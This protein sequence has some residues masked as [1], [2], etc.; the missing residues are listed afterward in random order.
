VLSTRASAVAVAGPALRDESLAF[1]RD[2]HRAAARVWVEAA[3]RA[4]ADPH[5]LDRMPVRWLGR[6]AVLVRGLLAERLLADETAVRR[7]GSLPRAL[8]VGALGRGGTPGVTEGPD[9]ASLACRSS[10]LAR[11]LRAAPA[12]QVALALDLELDEMESAWRDAGTGLVHDSASVAFGRVVL[13]WA[14]LPQSIWGDDFRCRTLVRAAEAS[15]ASAR[16]AMSVPD[17]RRARRCRG[18]WE[19]WALEAVLATR[20]GDV[21]PRVGSLLD[22]LAGLRRSDGAHVA[23]P[24]VASLL[25]DAVAP[26]VGSACLAAWTALALTHHPHWQARLRVEHLGP[27]RGEARVGHRAP[28]RSTRGTARTASSTPAT[29]TGPV[30]TA[31]ALEAQRLFCAAP[32][33]VVTARRDL[34]VAGLAVGAGDRVV[35]D[36]HA[37]NHDERRWDDAESFDPGRFLPRTGERRAGPRPFDATLDPVQQQLVTVLLAATMTRIATML[38][39]LGPDTGN[40]GDAEAD[41]WVRTALGTRPDGIRV[42]LTGTR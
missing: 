10:A 23:A 35:V 36:V 20:S 18:S 8:A 24:E 1:A 31:V 28:T 5:A 17:A 29:P 21:T 11:A 27:R 41:S 26:V 25:L 14:G 39:D 3:S 4:G 19:A 15:P 34:D 12:R 16:S 7:G 38:P 9:D 22:D 2:G 33:L 30:A 6:R 37:S 42:D 40:E 13:R 32:L